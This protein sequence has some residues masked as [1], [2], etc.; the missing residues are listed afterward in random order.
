MKKT[1]WIAI[2]GALAVSVI[3]ASAQDVLSGNAVGYVKVD[4]SN[5]FTMIN[6]PF[7]DMSGGP[8]MFTNTIG[9]QVMGV[10]AIVYRYS[11]VDW[12]SYPFDRGNWNNAAGLVL[13]PG[14]AY[15]LKRPNSWTGTSNITLTGEVPE[16][17]NSQR[18]VTG[19]GNFTTVSFA[20]PAEVKFTNTLLAA[21]GGGVGASIFAYNGTDWTSYPYDRGN[22][23]NAASLVLKPGVGYFFKAATASGGF[24]WSQRRPY[25]WP[26]TPLPASNGPF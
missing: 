11:G 15:F 5:T 2:I 4:I 26:G 22:W 20:Y 13:E 7:D 18:A 24:V 25:T 1:L 6:M 14:V 10:G 9:P 23:N 8:T 16:A 3:A 21:Q 19:A 12:T 17:T